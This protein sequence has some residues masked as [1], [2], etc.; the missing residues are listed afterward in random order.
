MIFSPGH[1]S[2]YRGVSRQG[3]AAELRVRLISAELGWW[4]LLSLQCIML[5]ASASAG[6]E[7]LVQVYLGRSA[8]E[9]A[10]DRR[11]YFCPTL[12]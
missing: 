1:R 10:S 6:G 7:G 3:G 12:G 9:A 2:C 5:L 11:W 4:S 8:K